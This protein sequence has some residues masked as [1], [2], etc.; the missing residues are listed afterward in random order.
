M[1]NDDLVIGALEGSAAQVEQALR[2][3]PDP[4]ARNEAGMSP[5]AAMSSRSE[6]CVRLLLEARADKDAVHPVCGETA[7]CKAAELG[8]VALTRLLLDFGADKNKPSSDRHTPLGIAADLG[9]VE[10]AAFLLDAGADT[11]MPCD[12]GGATPLIMAA[13]H[14]HPEV[15][16][17]LV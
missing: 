10:V 14:N 11:E 1:V 3:R 13:L 7:L 5:D 15:V 9:H 12:T 8:H 4:N 16:K 2:H 17:L 6:S